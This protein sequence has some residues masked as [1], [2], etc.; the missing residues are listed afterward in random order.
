MRKK[1]ERDSQGKADTTFG[2]PRNQY[3][4]VTC[5]HYGMQMRGGRVTCEKGNAPSFVYIYRAL[6]TTSDKVWKGNKQPQAGD[7]HFTYIILFSKPNMRVQYVPIQRY[8][9][10]MYAVLDAPRRGLKSSLF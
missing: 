6:L 2:A 1:Q 10:P 7:T 5:S 8:V 9:G 4:F 3:N